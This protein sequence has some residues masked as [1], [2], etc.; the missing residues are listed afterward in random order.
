VSLAVEAYGQSHLRN[1]PTLRAR[2]LR[3][4]SGA[5]GIS[6]A[7]VAGAF[8]PVVLSFGRDREAWLGRGMNSIALAANGPPLDRLAAS[9]VFGRFEGRALYAVINDVVLDTLSD[10]LPS[11][12]PA[13][14]FHRSVIG[15]ALTWRPGRSFEVTIG[16]TI[17]ISRGSRTLEFGYANPLMPYILTQNDADRDG[18]SARDNLLLFAS[19]TGRAGSA[20]LTGELLIDDLQLDEEREVTPNQLAWRLDARYGF[21]SRI[22]LSIGAEYE[23]VDGYTYLRGLYTDVYQFNDHP[24]GSELGPDSD[25]LLAVG[26]AWLNDALRV[27]TSVGVWRRGAQRIARR[28]ARGAVNAGADGFLTTTAEDPFVQRA[29][30]GTAAV[31]FLRP[32]FPVVLA[33]E[34]ARIDHPDHTSAG[35]ATYVRAYLKATYAFRYP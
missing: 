34:A 26:E 20:R 23:R 27:S 14:R 35:A 16:E 12:T 30:L 22:P 9:L 1:D 21:G 4:T 3:S 19:A 10:G 25:R 29:M 33:A 7:T 13:Q 24:L 6:E 31:E 32:L 5:V 28:P 17:L 11:G 2:A 15:H 18:S 8:G